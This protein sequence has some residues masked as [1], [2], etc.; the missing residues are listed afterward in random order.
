M[1]AQ[2]L[3]TAY[4]DGRLDLDEHNDRLA[5]AYDA[6]TFGELNRLTTDLVLPRPE[7]APLV[8]ALQVADVPAPAGSF[9]GGN[10]LFSTFKPGQLGTVAP[11]VTLNAWIGE[12]RL[13]LVGATFA[14]RQTTIQVGGLMCDV[15]IRVPE[16]VTVNASGLSALMSETKVEGVVGHQDGIVLNL[17]GTVVMGEV[18]VMGP[19][20]KA[21]R[22]QK[23]VR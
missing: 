4:A 21:S 8:E 10:A 15:K 2:L 14:N 5:A 22:Y 23:F 12:I 20:S 9:T 11:H 17:V 16:G 19:Q 7:P 3:N 13:D 1:V 6:K 18:R